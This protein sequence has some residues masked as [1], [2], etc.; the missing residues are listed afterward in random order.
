MEDDDIQIEQILREANAYGLKPEVKHYAERLLQ[1]N[2][3]FSKI[4]AYVRAYH[5]L[6][7]D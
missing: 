4:D 2:P 6:I 7:K 3:R 1:K 5:E